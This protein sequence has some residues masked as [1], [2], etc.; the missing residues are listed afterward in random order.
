MPLGTRAERPISSRRV[1][2]HLAEAL[3]V[4]AAFPGLVRAQPGQCGLVPVLELT[5][6]VDGQVLAAG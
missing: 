1:L 5:D 4:Q 6:Q 2:A 3:D